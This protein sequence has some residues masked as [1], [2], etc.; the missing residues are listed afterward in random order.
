MG[1]RQMGQGGPAQA[2]GG[3]PGPEGGSTTPAPEH[4]APA[5]FDEDDSGVD[6]HDDHDEAPDQ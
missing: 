5:P 4:H 1:D 2:G 6:T 3:A